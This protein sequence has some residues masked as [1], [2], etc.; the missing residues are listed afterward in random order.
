[1]RGVDTLLLSGNAITD[2]GV[3]EL[4]KSLDRNTALKNAD[5]GDNPAVTA[6]AAAR[7]ASKV[8]ETGLRKR[9]DNLA[10]FVADPQAEWAEEKAISESAEEGQDAV[11]VDGQSLGVDGDGEEILFRGG[12][13]YSNDEL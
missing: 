10:S 8:G 13:E 7:L 2:A 6:A 4:V 3:D 1:V 11:P 9:R 5:V 12:V